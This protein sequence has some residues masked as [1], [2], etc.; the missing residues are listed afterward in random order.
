MA[1]EAKK[2]NVLD[3]QPRKAVGVS[4]PFSGKA[5]FNSTFQT[6]DAIKNNLINYFLTGR[7]ERYLNALF[8]FGLRIELFENITETKLDALDAKA[9]EALRVYF[10]KVLPREIKLTSDPDMN[11]VGFYLAYSIAD[12]GIDDELL[13]NVST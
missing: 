4:L 6:K 1:F 8:G 2:I 9:R 11:T 13:I 3:L 7:N 10:P 12:T 5:V